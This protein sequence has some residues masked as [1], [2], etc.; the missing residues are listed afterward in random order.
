MNESI[1]RDQPETRPSPARFRPDDSADFGRRAKNLAKLLEAGLQ[2]TQELLAKAYGY[3][4]LHEL[5]QALKDEGKPGPY[6]DLLFSTW[7]EVPNDVPAEVKFERQARLMRLIAHWQRASPG[8]PS[9]NRHALACDL[10]LFSSPAAHRAH[11]KETMTFLESGTGYSS[12]GFPFGFRGTIHLRYQW[13]L[14]FAQNARAV[15][16]ETPDLRLRDADAFDPDEQL[17]IL[18]QYRAPHLFLAMVSEASPSL[19][20]G[21]PEI[22]VEYD[23]RTISEFESLVQSDMTDL[24]VGYLAELRE[25]RTHTAIDGGERIKLRAAVSEPTRERVQACAMAS[26]LPD[27]QENLPRWRMSLRLQLAKAIVE[28]QV[29]PENDYDGEPALVTLGNENRY[30]SMLLRPYRTYEDIQHWEV[31]ATLLLRDEQTGL[32]TIAGILGGDYIIPFTDDSYCNP[33]GVL[34]LFD[35]QGNRELYRVWLLLQ[36]LYFGRVGYNNISDWTDDEGGG[37]VANLFAWVAPEHRGKEVSQWLFRDFV[38]TFESGDADYW[39][40]QWECWTDPDVEDGDFDFG[41]DLPFIEVGVIFVPLARTGVLGYSVWEGDAEHAVG[42]LLKSGSERVPREIRMKRRFPTKT[43]R[44]GI[45]GRL[46]DV[47]KSVPSDFVF[48]DP[49]EA[50]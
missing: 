34:N 25:S 30:L 44:S 31:S 28:Q 7:G 23:F 5:Q 3:A 27:L 39:D 33:S 18:R 6:D 41:S 14:P 24:I 22:Q 42:R 46:L 17:K 32:W 12:E 36:D 1:T 47:V 10:A 26:G 50:A 21:A 48:Y 20:D 15:L 35:D 37:A 40:A 49:A 13:R 8:H 4:N 43:E 19:L 2:E 29:D 38:H 45:G 11:A 16:I 9:L